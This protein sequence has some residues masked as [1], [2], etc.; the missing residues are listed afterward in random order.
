MPGHGIGDFEPP[1][2]RGFAGTPT[3]RDL[4]PAILGSIAEVTIFGLTVITSTINGH[5]EYCLPQT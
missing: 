2:L 1:F 3:R 4:R 5:P